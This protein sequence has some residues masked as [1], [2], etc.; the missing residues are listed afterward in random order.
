MSRLG[1]LADSMLSIPLQSA[2]QG[3]S[4]CTAAGAVIAS[5]FVASAIRV[6]R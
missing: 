2:L 6:Q 3:C 4:T 1:L 5:V